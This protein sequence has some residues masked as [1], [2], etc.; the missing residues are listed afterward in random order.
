MTNLIET[1]TK[2]AIM[3]EFKSSK[4]WNYYGN[5]PEADNNWTIDVMWAYKHDTKNQVKKSCKEIL[6]K[7]SSTFINGGR[8]ITKE[9]M[10][11]RIKVVKIEIT[12]TDSNIIDEDFLKKERQKSA[13]RK[14]TQ[15]EIEDLDLLELAV[16]H[17][18]SE[19][20]DTEDLEDILF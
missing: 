13:L 1:T 20:D 2:Y 16:L 14:L 7:Y 10:P 5:R 19:D 9:G 18:L 11:D 6:K 15:Q 3:G 8:V 17:R 12:V 4:S